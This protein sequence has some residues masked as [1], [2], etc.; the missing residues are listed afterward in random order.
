MKIIFAFFFLISSCAKIT[1]LD[2]DTD[3]FNKIVDVMKTKSPEDLYQ[4]FGKPDEISIESENPD[5]QILKYKTSLIDAY[6]DKQ[7]HK[8][9]HL[10][11]FY[12]KEVDNYTS[13]KERFKN[14]KWIETQIPNNVKSDV[15]TDL[16]LVKIPEINMEF[17]YDNN[18]PK[19]KVMW[20]YFD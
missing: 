16:Y 13:L 4:H 10:T 8:L 15:L 18:A 11:L 9:T 2:Q 17:Q 14:Y 7:T 1:P 20:I 12:W 3:K 5:I 6:L 19:R